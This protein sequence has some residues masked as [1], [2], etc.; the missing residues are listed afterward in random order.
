MQRLQATRNPAVSVENFIAYPLNRAV[1]TY[2]AFK[3]I[4]LLGAP[5]ILFFSFVQVDRLQFR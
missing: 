4:L 3:F 2:D 1:S 5:F